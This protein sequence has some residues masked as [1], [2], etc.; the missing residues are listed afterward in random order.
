MQDNGDRAYEL[1][2]RGKE[3][4]ERLGNAPVARFIQGQ[5]LL[6]AFDLGRWDDFVREANEFIAAC[7][8][9][10]PHYAEGYA[11]ERRADVWLARD[12]PESAAPDAARALELARQV[13]EPQSLQPAL[14]V[15]IR[16]DLALGRLAEA[17]RTARELLSLLAST[18]TGFGI[19]T[20]AL[21]ADTLGVQEELPAV[22]TRLPDRTWTRAAAA[23]VDGD[24]VRAADIVGESA[25]RF[26]EAVL[27]LRA[28]E[29]L[30]ED[31]R[32]R[33]ADV[34]LQKALAFFRSVGATRYL[35]EGER[36]LAAPGRE[37][38]A[39]G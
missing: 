8:A 16:V 23:I 14:A 9:G 38:S 12:D 36:L 22:L 10:S 27:R 33:E 11:R 5:L 30:V 21:H 26:D 17:Q 3:A 19:T 6:A 24:L 32:R 2:L 7:E 18:T 35:R 25:W 34:Q 31:G 1:Q 28:A 39:D 4:A 37:R 15:Q 29:A 13:K 20:L